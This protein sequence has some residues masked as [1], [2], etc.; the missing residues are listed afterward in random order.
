M[1]HEVKFPSAGFSRE[2]PPTFTYTIQDIY[3]CKLIVACSD[4]CPLFLSDQHKNTN[5]PI[6]EGHEFGY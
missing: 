1:D 6:R 4:Y 5:K 3:L 2:T